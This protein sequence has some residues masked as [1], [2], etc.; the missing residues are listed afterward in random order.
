MN[1]RVIREPSIAG[2]TLGSLYVDDVRVMDTLEDQL[3]E[4]PG[5][6]VESWK[7]KAQ[8]AIPAGRYRVR[9]TMSAR[10][11]KTLPLLDPV[12]GF[13][14]IRIHA[15]NVHRD[16]EGCLLVGL[17]RSEFGADPKV[18]RSREAMNRLMLFLTEAKGEVWIVIENPPSYS[19]AAA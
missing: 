4:Q 6:P 15:G 19:V 16:T 14:G 10:F 13:S 1:L 17:D 5:K 11:G 9:L 7:V 12:P 8:T 18:Y 3:R 2:A